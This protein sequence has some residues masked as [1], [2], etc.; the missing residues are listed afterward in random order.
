MPEREPQGQFR[1]IERLLSE[2]SVRRE[3][4]QDM[5]RV[6][7]VDY[8]EQWKLG[9]I[10]SGEDRVILIPGEFDEGMGLLERANRLQQIP[11]KRTAL[12][13]PT[14]MF[15]KRDG[16][17][18]TG[19]GVKQIYPVWLYALER[20]PEKGGSMPIS[21]IT[22]SPGALFRR[23]IPELQASL[24]HRPQGMP[25]PEFLKRQG[26]SLK[27]SYEDGNPFHLERGGIITPDGMVHHP[28]F[29]LQRSLIDDEG[30]LI[31]LGHD[32]EAA[33]MDT[34]KMQ[35]AFYKRLAQQ[36]FRTNGP[37]PFLIR[38][39]SHPVCDETML[40]ILDVPM[41][42]SN[43]SELVVNPQGKARLFTAKDNSDK[44]WAEMMSRLQQLLIVE[45][46]KKQNR[47]LALTKD[48]AH[49][50]EYLQQK[51]TILSDYFEIRDLGK[52]N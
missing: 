32:E 25:I 47:L 43:W 16:L 36:G 15:G 48:G 23:N 21:D 26:F 1:Q 20:K 13:Y 40:P 29:F 7:V 8:K 22:I 4:A 52:L 37:F 51:E 3:I 24:G 9:V 44:Q 28:D 31:C 41:S 46:R 11:L 30:N 19:G 42:A 50:Q 17:N 2:S 5:A 10:R 6:G 45:M 35:P 12:L 34:V 49:L 18:V 14:V 39:R 33:T 38:Y 27:E